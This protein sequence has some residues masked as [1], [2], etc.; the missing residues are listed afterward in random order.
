MSAIF[1]SSIPL[2][3]SLTALVLTVSSLVWGAALR[4]ADLT[5]LKRDRDDMRSELKSTMS[6]VIEMRSD[7]KWLRTQQENRP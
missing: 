4:D 1:K 2:A 3:A 7:I 5:Q 6:L